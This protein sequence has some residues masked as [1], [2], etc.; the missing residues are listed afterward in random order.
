MTQSIRVRLARRLVHQENTSAG[1]TP[2]DR[3]LRFVRTSV[4]L[5]GALHQARLHDAQSMAIQLMDEFRV[6]L[7]V[8]HEL[9]RAARFAVPISPV[10]PFQKTIPHPLAH[11]PVSRN[12]CLP[13]LTHSLAI[14]LASVMS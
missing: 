5:S 2:N 9:D 8:V 12:S 13:L 3:D 7:M 1:K 6:Y 11:P 4:D 14:C 10:R